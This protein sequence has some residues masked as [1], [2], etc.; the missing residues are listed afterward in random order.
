MSEREYAVILHKNINYEEFRQEMVSLYGNDVIPQRSVHVANPRPGSRRIT[1]YSLTEQEVEI[2]K[3]DPRVLDIEVPPDQRSDIQLGLRASQ[4]GD[5]TKTTVSSGNFLNWGMRRVNESNNPYTGNTVTGGYSYTL[6]GTGVDVV[7]QDSGIQA[8]HPEFNDHNGVS[9]V[10]QIDWYTESGLAGTQPAGFY[11][12][13]DGHGTHVAGTAAGLTYGWAKG[14]RVYAQKLAGL[15]GN[16]QGNEDPNTGIPIADAFDTIR[17]WHRNK[18]V[19]PA[20]GYKR[21]TVVNMSW[22]YRGFYNTVS[23]IRYRGVSYTGTDIDTTT[24]RWNLGLVPLLNDDGRYVTNV[25]LTSVDVEIQEMFDEGIIVCIAAGNNRHKIDVPG[26]LD[27]DNYAETDIVR[28]YYHRGSSPYDDQVLIVGNIDSNLNIG[29]LEQK[30][31]SS[32]CGPGVNIYAPGTNIMSCTSNINKFA[33]GAYPLDG[34]FRIANISGTS[35]ASPQVAGLAALFLEINPQA[36]P[37]QVK[38]WLIIN[39]QSNMLYDSG[40]GNSYTDMNS[41]MDGNNR[42]LYNPFNSANQINIIQS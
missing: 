18:P 7:I 35:M 8:D 34:N 38:N 42:F 28:R 13:Y 21:P 16:I 41:L 39:A 36:T 17:L 2:L 37:G 31:N 6:D 26:G 14:S 30:S 25:R 22:G 10:Q 27:Y 24:E 29:G 40:V 4:T 11:T 12:D 5:F 33:D 23:E 9:R 3:N 20:T 32:E 15:Q 19:D 1:H